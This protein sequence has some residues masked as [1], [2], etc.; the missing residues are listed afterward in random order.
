MKAATGQIAD[1]GQPGFLLQVDGVGRGLRLARAAEWLLA[2]LTALFGALAVGLLGALSHP[3]GLAAYGAWLTALI[4]L[5]LGLLALAAWTALQRLPPYQVALG[6]ERRFPDL[7]DRLASAVQLLARPDPAPFSPALVRAAIRQGDLAAAERDLAAVVDWSRAYQGLKAAL[8]AFVLLLTLL[9]AAPHSVGSLLASPRPAGGLAAG[10]IPALALPEGLAA[11]PGPPLGD[12][13]VELAPPAYTGLPPTVHTDGLERLSA[14]VG[15]QVRVQAT[16]YTEVGPVLRLRDATGREQRQPMTVAR[17]GQAAGNF[18]LRKDIAWRILLEQAPPAGFATPEYSIGAIADALPTV[19]IEQPGRDLSMQQVS[20]VELSVSATDDF[21][22]AGLALMYRLRDDRSWRSVPLEITPGKTATARYTWDLAPLQLQPGDVV[23]YRAAATDND[24]VSGPRTG[25]SRTYGIR[26]PKP[27]AAQTAERVEQAEEQQAKTLEELRQQAQRLGEQISEL[28]QQV[29]QQGNAA[30][31]SQQAARLQEAARQAQDLAAQLDKAIA[32]TMQEMA[33]SELVTP[34]MMQK[35]GRMQQLLQETLN[36]D[37]RKALEQVQKALG[38]MSPEQ[39]RQALQ[40]AQL[41]QQEFMQ[42]LDQ[43]IALLEQVR[44]EQKLLRAAELAKKLVEEQKQLRDAATEKAEKEQLSEADHQDMQQEARRQEQAAEEAEK[45]SQQ[46]KELAR[47]LQEPHPQAAEPLKEVQKDLQGERPQRQ[48]QQAAQELS[49]GDPQRAQAQQAWA[50]N[51]LRLEA[52]ALNQAQAQMLGQFRR[53]LAG[54]LQRMM[55]DAL[56]LSQEQERLRQETLPLAQRPQPQAMAQKRLLEGLARD[57]QALSRGAQGLS[58]EM[59]ELSKKTPLMQPGM[60]QEAQGVGEMMAQAGRDIQGGSIPQGA[61]RQQAAL[62]QLNALAERLMEMTQGAANASQSMA[63]EQYLK[64]LESLAQ[65][66]QRLN[67]QTQQQL[68]QGM[69]M[70]KPGLR[71]EGRYGPQA[72][73]Q[74]LGQLAAEQELIRRALE[75]LLQQAEGGEGRLGEQLGNVPS[76]MEDVE[77][78][79]E[80]YKADRETLKTQADILHKMLDAQRS[81]H[82]KSERPERK[83]VQAKPYQPP[84]SPPALKK[85]EGP[86]VRPPTINPQEPLPLGFEDL[87]RRY[88][89]AVGR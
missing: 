17:E 84:P 25:Y 30:L 46:V 89:E 55:R 45:L 82:T 49:K 62:G 61:A 21:G 85:S 38:Q 64:Q 65:R 58:R 31:S 88:M 50:L 2:A 24:A 4:G 26:I 39:L 70:P 78:D 13:R 81:L 72:G 68:G 56:Y 54:A 69:P 33:R 11:R 6:L 18:V 27:T 57:Q 28:R 87:V 5:P 15:T 67:E 1:V 7:D 83:A 60:S 86:K 16:V 36:E 14:L 40:E 23:L 3:L 44:L 32:N 74:Q 35:V 79:L 19:N 43:T 8:A 29:E 42:R 37:L 52:S 12:L 75:K 71:A 77:K 73:G 22:V 51:T 80:Q 20:P 10:T 34:E 47:E 48:M 59:Q 53:E 76:Q 9:A 41:N 66:Q 63:L